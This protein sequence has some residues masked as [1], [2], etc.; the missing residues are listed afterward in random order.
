MVL[1]WDITT[2]P[3]RGVSMSQHYKGRRSDQHKTGPVHTHQHLHTQPCSETKPLTLVNHVAVAIRPNIVNRHLKHCSL[4]HSSVSAYRLRVNYRSFTVMTSDIRTCICASVIMQ[5]GHL[6]SKVTQ[7]YLYT[8]QLYTPIFHVHFTQTGV[9]V[10]TI[11][12][13]SFQ[14]LRHLYTR[15]PDTPSADVNVIKR[16]QEIPNG[17]VTFLK[18]KCR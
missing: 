2:C 15:V 1:V 13:Q 17:V 12:T 8:M 5:E 4:A 9:H 10:T 18:S 6:I 16:L 11:F 7:V 3:W 14:N